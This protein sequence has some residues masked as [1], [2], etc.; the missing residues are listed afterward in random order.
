MKQNIIKIKVDV[1]QELVQFMRDYPKD[2][3]SL[4]AIG[5]SISDGFS[6]SEPGKLLLDRNS[7]LIDFGNKNGLDVETYHLSRS[8]NNNSLSVYDWILQN[9]C[10]KDNLVKKM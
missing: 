10:E 2:Q 7:H 1:L 8:E 9:C 6:M 3:L 5:N 4:T